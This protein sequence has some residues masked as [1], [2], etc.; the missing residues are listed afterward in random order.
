[1]KQTTYQP[2]RAEIINLESQ[3]VLCASGASS[4]FGNSTESV[5]T[6]TFSIP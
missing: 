6:H 1:M 2:P 5:P 4:L 3:G